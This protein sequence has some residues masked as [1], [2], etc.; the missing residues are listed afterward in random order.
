LDAGHRWI[1]AGRIARL[2][3]GAARKMFRKTAFLR[4]SP[5]FFKKPIKV[6]EKR[7]DSF[8]VEANVTTGAIRSRSLGYVNDTDVV[9]RI[10]EDHH[11]SCN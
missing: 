6:F 11:V 3:I 7:A 2:L 10:K 4:G 1:F 5:T 8:P 9:F